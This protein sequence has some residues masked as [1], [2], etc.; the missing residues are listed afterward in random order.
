[1]RELSRADVVSE[2][3]RMLGADSKDSGARRH[4]RELLR[5]A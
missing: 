5:A 1:V 2:L 4:A 3:V